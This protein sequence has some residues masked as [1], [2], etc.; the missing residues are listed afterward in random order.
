MLNTHNLLTEL[1][2]VYGQGA[3]RS[4]LSGNMLVH[5]PSSGYTLPA[6]DEYARR[7]AEAAET[8]LRFARERSR[9][10]EETLIRKSLHSLA[11]SLRH[12]CNGFCVPSKL[13]GTSKHQPALWRLTRE[14]VG[15][16]TL[17]D[18]EEVK[19]GGH[20][21]LIVSLDGGVLGEVQAKW[22]PVIRPLRAFHAEVRLVRVT[23]H[24]HDGYRLGLNCFFALGDSVEALERALGSDLV[25][26]PDTGDGYGGH[27]VAVGPVE[28]DSI[29]LRAP[30]T[31]GGDG[32]AGRTPVA[33][34]AV[35]GDIRFWRDADGTLRMNV[36]HVQK[37]SLSP[38]I[39]YAG[40]GPADSA[41]SVLC[42]VTSREEAERCYQLYKH[43]VISCLNPNGATITR[44]SVQEWL[45]RH[46]GAESA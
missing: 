6:A 31:G 13:S 30:R 3:L 26:D 39:G 15:F 9:M 5:E 37:H 19:D 16:G 12:R 43:E 27:G 28:P 41:L 10:R 2:L 14:H 4:I 29:A 23:G 22:I 17:L 38:E 8:F 33:Q 44:A 46:T 25:P 18:V 35:G 20:V 1:A 7:Q 21:R 32:A 11:F 45:D 24:E 42:A 40:S 34:S 36:P